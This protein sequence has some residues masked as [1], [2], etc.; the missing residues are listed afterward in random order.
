[1]ARCPPARTRRS[2][3]APVSTRPCCGSPSSPL[4][5]LGGR[6]R[7][8]R[9]CREPTWAGAGP[10]RADCARDPGRVLA[11]MG[12]DSG[13]RAVARRRFGRAPAYPAVAG[14]RG[15]IR[16]RARAR[17]PRLVL[18]AVR[19][20]RPWGLDR[21][22]AWST[23]AP[24]DWTRST[25]AAAKALLAPLL[26]PEA[27]PRCRDLRCR[28]GPARPRAAS[29]PRGP[30]AAGRAAL[31]RGARGR[32]SPGRGRRARRDAPTRGRRGPRG[33]DPGV[34]AAR[35]PRPPAAAH[36]Y[37]GSSQFG[38]RS[39]RHLHTRRASAEATPRPLE[40]PVGRRTADLAPGLTTRIVSA[41]TGNNAFP[42]PVHAHV[43]DP[44]REHPSAS[45]ETLSSA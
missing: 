20:P 1:M 6:H 22:A 9:R 43:A 16:E 3:A 30:G 34:P 8:D 10:G 7:A 11:S 5:A 4:C 40:L 29:R 27:A 15:T 2:R 42:E 26:A 13:H 35:N 25:T 21:R 24:H 19:P 14:A 38:G 28:R 23:T 45:C 32:P 44:E 36:P 31:G 12:R 37:P 39:P 18:D 33:R 17:S 41:R